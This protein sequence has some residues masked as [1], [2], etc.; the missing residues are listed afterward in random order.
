MMVKWNKNK[1]IGIYNRSLI[2]RHKNVEK[3][4]KPINRPQNPTFPYPSHRIVHRNLLKN[5]NKPFNRQRIDLRDLIKKTLPTLLFHSLQYPCLHLV[6]SINPYIIP[7]IRKYQKFFTSL[8]RYH[9]KKWASGI[10]PH[11]QVYG[12]AL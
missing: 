7:R 8:A 12:I 6:R 1:I 10:R 2:I 9:I 11:D 5:K 3:T 4:Y